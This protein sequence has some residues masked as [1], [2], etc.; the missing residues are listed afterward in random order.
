[1]KRHKY[2]QLIII[3]HHFVK[4]LDGVLTEM[5]LSSNV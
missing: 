2:N 4:L 5:A 1:M 3:F